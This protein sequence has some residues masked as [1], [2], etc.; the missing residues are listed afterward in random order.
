MTA[1]GSSDSHQNPVRLFPQFFLDSIF[2]SE[3]IG[4]YRERAA[5]YKFYSMSQN[6]SRI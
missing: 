4:I 1:L 3:I 5:A 2:V 6:K